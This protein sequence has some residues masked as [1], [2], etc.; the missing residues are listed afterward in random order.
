[1]K[2]II[3]IGTD[4]S[5]ALAFTR[6]LNTSNELDWRVT[7]VVRYASSQIPISINREADITQKFEDEC[8]LPIY[9]QITDV[10]LQN[11]DA[12]MIVN[13]NANEHFEWFQKLVPHGKPI[14]IDKPLTYDVSEVDGFYHLASQK[15]VTLNSSSSLRHV[16]F[17]KR[18]RH[19]LLTKEKAHV[20]IKAPLLLEKNIPSFYWYGIHAIEILCEILEG[21]KTILSIEIDNE[22]VK[23]DGTSQT[24]PFQLEMPINKYCDF[25]VEVHTSDEKVTFKH[26]LD[27]EPLYDYLLKNVLTQFDL[28]NCSFDYKRTREVITLTDKLNKYFEAAMKEVD[29]NEY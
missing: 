20:V 14:F 28:P 4:S 6:L 13:V 9:N 7:G 22:V 18:C 26:L 19:Y 12:F 16:P 27:D 29:T 15:E 25:S 3:L 24:H 8:Q 17:V 1:M 23:I 5:H 2:N 11:I 21:E 10:P